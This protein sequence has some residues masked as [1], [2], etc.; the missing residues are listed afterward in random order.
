MAFFTL[1]TSSTSSFFHNDH[2]LCDIIC[3]A[4]C[5]TVVGISVAGDN[6][7]VGAG[8]KRAI[9]QQ[10]DHLHDMH[11]SV[12]QAFTAGV[13]CGTASLQHLQQHARLCQ[14]VPVQLLHY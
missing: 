11:E 8:L 12:L 5:G 7:A 1:F 10:H 4:S 13:E 3:M 9:P 14:V 6:A 2:K